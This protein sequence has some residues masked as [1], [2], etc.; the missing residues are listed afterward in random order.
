MQL[1]FLH[2]NFIWFCLL[3]QLVMHFC[4]MSRECGGRIVERV[5]AQAL[6]TA[7]GADNVQVETRLRVQQMTR[8]NGRS[9]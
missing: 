7:N 9:L 3:Y 5:G 1:M 2:V 8:I 6:M 4:T